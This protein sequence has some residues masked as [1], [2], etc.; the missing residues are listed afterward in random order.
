MTVTSDVPEVKPSSSFHTLR[1]S[2]VLKRRVCGVIHVNKS[3]GA[4]AHRLFGCFLPVRTAPQPT[5]RGMVYVLIPD[6]LRTFTVSSLVL[7]LIEPFTPHDNDDRKGIH[8]TR[9]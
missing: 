1:T 5:S 7:R 9:H 2:P 3:P 4:T 6:P 8:I